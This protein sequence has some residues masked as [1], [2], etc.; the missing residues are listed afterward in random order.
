[1]RLN[2]Q[3]RSRRTQAA[4]RVRSLLLLSCPR[5]KKIV[6]PLPRP[7]S[8]WV[9]KR[10]ASLEDLVNARRQGN[11]VLGEPRTKWITSTSAPSSWS[12]SPLRSSPSSSM[13]MPTAHSWAPTCSASPFLCS[14]PK[15]RWSGPGWKASPRATPE[16]SFWPSATVSSIR[17]TPSAS[18]FAWRVSIIPPS[19]PA[20]S[21]PTSIS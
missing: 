9:R 5:G 7:T 14:W 15:R 21:V 13:T 20:K 4:N 6:T 17:S 18:S 8:S 19:C 12:R 2:E 16:Q 10:R 1:M 3:A 11:F